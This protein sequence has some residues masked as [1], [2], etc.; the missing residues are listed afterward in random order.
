M[1]KKNMVVSSELTPDWVK[2]VGTMLA[3]IFRQM[4]LWFKEP[5]KG[6]S[7]D[8][9][10]LFIEHRNPFAKATVKLADAFEAIRRDWETFYKDVFGLVVDFSALRIP[11]CPGTGWRLIIIAMGIGPELAYQIS[12]QIFGKAWKYH[13]ASL[14]VVIVKNERSNKDGAYAIWVCDGQEADEVHKNKSANQIEAEKL[15]TETGLERLVHGLKYFKETGKQLDVKTITLC[16]GSRYY[17]GSV[18]R[19]YWNSGYD[20]LYVYW[21]NPGSAHDR[22]RAREV[23]C[24]E[25]R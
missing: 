6:L 25:D 18:P 20:K 4:C 19:V 21:C 8:Q 15:F 1:K 23:S 5:G 16:S 3:E 12:K 22:L 13:D 2:K 10:Q 17:D 11:K 7:L 9:L 24:E 14:D